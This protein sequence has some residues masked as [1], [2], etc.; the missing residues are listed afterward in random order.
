MSFKILKAKSESGNWIYAPGK[1][2]TLTDAALKVVGS[3]VVSCCT[4]ETRS[5]S[6]YEAETG[7]PDIDKSPD[8]QL[9]ALLP[10]AD[11]GI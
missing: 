3:E 7:K 5:S 1:N 8:Y 2:A 4:L 9:V 6:Q 11:A 10:K